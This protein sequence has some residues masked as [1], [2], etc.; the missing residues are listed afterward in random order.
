MTVCNSLKV[1]FELFSTGLFTMAERL[2]RLPEVM[3]LMARVQNNLEGGFIFGNPV[4][5]IKA[6][7]V[8]IRCSID[9]GRRIHE[10]RLGP[11]INLTGARKQKTLRRVAMGTSVS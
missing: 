3:L 7:D 4:N 9:P 11:I 8:F 2:A 6:P 1:G 5:A 10:P